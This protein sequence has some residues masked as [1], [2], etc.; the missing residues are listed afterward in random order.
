[1]AKNKNLPKAPAGPIDRILILQMD[2]D[3]KKEIKK[4]ADK[5]KITSVEWI[6]QLVDQK[7]HSNIQEDDIS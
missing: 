3:I 5:A 6:M 7:L 4:A 2:P 1:M